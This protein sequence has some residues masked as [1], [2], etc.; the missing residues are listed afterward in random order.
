MRTRVVDVEEFE[1]RTILPAMLA[2]EGGILP[3]R[4]SGAGTSAPGQEDHAETD[5]LDTEDPYDAVDYLG[6]CRGY[7]L[8]PNRIFPDIEVGDVRGGTP[9]LRNESGATG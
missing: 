4:A 3:V 2:A 9:D 1:A 7:P 8:R 6:L 5:E